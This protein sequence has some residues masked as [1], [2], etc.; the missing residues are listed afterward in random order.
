MTTIVT[1]LMYSG[2]QNP[3]WELTPEQAKNLK[4]ILGEKKEVTLEMSAIS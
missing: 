4:S 1:A 3:S 2:K